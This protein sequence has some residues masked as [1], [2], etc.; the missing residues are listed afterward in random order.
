[1]EELTPRTQKEETVRPWD[2]KRALLS[3]NRA[4]HHLFPILDGARWLGGI[5]SQA[6][7]RWYLRAGLHADHQRQLR[8]SN[9][10]PVSLHMVWEMTGMWSVHR[11]RL[12]PYQPWPLS[13]HTLT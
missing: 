9:C 13:R 6:Q 8:S 7:E 11:L 2:E 5:F 4:Q 12:K 1:M 10:A 3:L